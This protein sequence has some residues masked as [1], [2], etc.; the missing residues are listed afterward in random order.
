MTGHH[1][2]HVTS[3]SVKFHDQN[4]KPINQ[5]WPCAVT[6]TPFP[7]FG[8]VLEYFG[9]L[10]ESHGLCEEPL[11]LRLR[12]FPGRGVGGAFREGEKHLVKVFDK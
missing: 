12:W 6:A 2:P 4:A 1:L 7:L 3:Q 11:G 8:W 10:V 9:T 5:R